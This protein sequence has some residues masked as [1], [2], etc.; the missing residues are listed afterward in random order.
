[1]WL[2]F[3]NLTQVHNWESLGKRIQRSP[4]GETEKVLANLLKDIR[5]TP[6]LR[7]YFKT[8][9]VESKSKSTTFENLWTLFAPETLIVAKPFLNTKQI[10]KV[11]DYSTAP[12]VFRVWAWQW[13]W[14]G[15]I[16]VKVKYDLRV[17]RFRGERDVAN[18]PY[19]PLTYHEGGPDAL[20]AIV[21]ERSLDFIKATAR[22]ESRTSPVFRYHQL[23]Y[24]HFDKI[25]PAEKIQ[26]SYTS[27]TNSVLFRE[28]S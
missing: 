21:R 4:N 10:L 1:L 11:A 22:C 26:V 19:Y 12:H 23:A 13:D 17:E 27:V 28:S 14:N 3:S 9:N 16:M 25:V 15:T 6:E 24:A 2:T 18:L 20:R 5:S 8:R 7:E